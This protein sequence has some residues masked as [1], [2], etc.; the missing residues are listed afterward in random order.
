MGWR[1]ARN[2]FREGLVTCREGLVTCCLYA[3]KAGT[4][5]WTGDGRDGGAPRAYP[6][7][8]SPLVFSDISFARSLFRLVWVKDIII[9]RRFDQISGRNPLCGLYQARYEKSRRKATCPPF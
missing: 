8:V 9:N 2:L 4:S 1:R 5:G 3:G 7:N 6:P